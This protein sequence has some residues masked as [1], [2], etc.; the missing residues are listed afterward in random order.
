MSGAPIAVHVPAPAGEV[1]KSA[2]MTP[3]PPAS[4]EFAVT[5]IVPAAALPSAGAVSEPVGA[6]AS[7]SHV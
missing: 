5:A 1:S 4:A 7:T 3:L 2:C 6:V